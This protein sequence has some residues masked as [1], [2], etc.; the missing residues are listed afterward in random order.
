[1]APVSDSGMLSP[2]ASQ[3]VLSARLAR[4]VGNH[5]DCRCNPFE[6]LSRLLA[7]FFVALSHCQPQPLF[8]RVPAVQQP[9][10]GLAELL[11]GTCPV[12]R[13]RQQCLR[14]TVSTDGAWVRTAAGADDRRG[15]YGLLRLRLASA[16]AVSGR[17]ERTHWHMVACGDVCCS[18]C[19]TVRSFRNSEWFTHVW[20]M[21]VSGG[22]GHAKGSRTVASCRVYGPAGFSEADA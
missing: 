20:I 17:A 22:T 10:D 7:L 15:S 13:R 19:P 5:L 3:F 1:M 12:L 8:S 18:H 11:L 9:F 6:V 14:R 21:D 2:E 4:S 16:A